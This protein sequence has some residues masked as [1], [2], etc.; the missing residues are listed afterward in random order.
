[1]D[2]A[3]K[4]WIGEVGQKPSFEERVEKYCP[5]LGFVLRLIATAAFFLA[6]LTMD[7]WV[8]I[9]QSRWSGGW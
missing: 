7:Y 6:L 5:I 8:P 4:E 3:N 1:M 9:V 2:V